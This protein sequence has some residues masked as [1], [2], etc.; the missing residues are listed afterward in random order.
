[1]NSSSFSRALSSRANLSCSS[2]V[3]CGAAGPHVPGGLEGAGRGASGCGA[4]GGAEGGGR[5]G[6]AAGPEVEAPGGGAGPYCRPAPAHKKLRGVRARTRAGPPAHLV[7]HD[8]AHRDACMP[9]PG[10]QRQDAQ[11]AHHLVAHRLVAHAHQRGVVPPGAWRGAGRGGGRG[12]AAH[13][14]GG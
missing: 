6:Q 11:Q 1:M 8:V 7:L 14:R 9:G 4:E 3:A 2:S 5:P 10:Q 12:G 13:S